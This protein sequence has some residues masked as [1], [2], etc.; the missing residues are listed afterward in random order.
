VFYRAPRRRN[1]ISIDEDTFATLEHIYEQPYNPS[2]PDTKHKW[3][4]FKFRYKVPV[5]DVFKHNV[6]TVRVRVLTRTLAFRQMVARTRGRVLTRQL[7]NR[8][9]WQMTYAKNLRS[10]QSQ[11]VVAARNSDISAHVNNDALSDLRRG[12]QP[13]DIRSFRSKRLINR[14]VS[15]IQERGE[16]RPVLGGYAWQDINNRD[17]VTS[18]DFTSQFFS[19]MLMYDMIIKRGLDPSYVANMSHRTMSSR[20][21]VGGLVRRQ[22]SRALTT[23]SEYNAQTRLMYGYVFNTDDMTTVRQT[24]EVSEQTMQ[25]QTFETDVQTHYEI[26]VNMTLYSE[27]M[28]IGNDDNTTL[29]VKFDLISNRTGMIVD[30]LIAPLDVEKHVENYR[31]P[32]EPP[33]LRIARAEDLSKFTLEITQRDPKATR[34]RVLQKK[35]HRN[36]PVIN[37]YATIGDFEIDKRLKTVRVP[38]I[39]PVN[40]YTIYRVISMGTADQLSYEFT[41]VVLRPSKVYPV[42]AVSLVTAFAEAGI[43]LE[44]RNIPTDVVSIQFLVKDKTIHERNWRNVGPPFVVDDSIRNLDFMTV[45]D[46]TVK[47]QHVYE[48]TVKMF[49]LAGSTELAG[50]ALIEFV[51]PESNVVT[52]EIS[53]IEI[54]QDDIPNV[55]FQMTTE[56]LDSNLDILTGLMKLREIE[57]YFTDSIA[58]ERDLF[59]QLVAHNVQ[60]VNITTGE[61][62]D[63]GVISDTIFNDDRSRRSNAVKPLDVRMKYRYEV[64]PLLRSPES[65]FERLS[66]NKVDEVTKKPYR[67]NP[68]KFLHPVTLNRGMIVTPLGR[69]TLFAKQ[70]MSHGIVGNVETIDVDF[71]RPPATINNIDAGRIDYDTVRVDWQID[72]QISQID[73]FIVMK[74]TLGSRT[75]IG[76]VHSEFT[77]NNA[78]FLHRITGDD[79]AQFRY[80]IVPVFNDY[81][82]GMKQESNYIEVQ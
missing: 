26:P 5:R 28:R 40:D 35:I 22:R 55:T 76:K 9:R 74:E 44:L 12:A 47:H 13:E 57:K 65:L 18:D 73:H 43:S 19:K 14:R 25:I 69:K 6:F 34:V 32:N 48:Y 39:T 15:D 68:A 4:R 54:A 56:L 37:D 77:D 72:G 82:I 2:Y 78:Y 66:K 41:N 52:T 58:D 75:I 11:F 67:Y 20:Q 64:Y 42:K 23:D 30:E 16:R 80:V 38:V 3:Y 29:V 1:I 49:Y 59:K 70:E 33:E 71:E 79:S 17:Q 50:H 62:E 81:T 27:K 10:Q 63:F 51:K 21:A 60:R 46:P 45:T 53:N 31:I 61:R 36:S 7:I 8:I 24:D